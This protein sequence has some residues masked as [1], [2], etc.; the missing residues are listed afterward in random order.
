MDLSAA[1]QGR[2]RSLPGASAHGACSAVGQLRSGVAC[3]R[4]PPCYLPADGVSSDASIQ[5]RMTVHPA[6]VSSGAATT[7][8]PEYPPP[9]LVLRHRSRSAGWRPH[10]VSA[11]HGRTGSAGGAGGRRTGSGAGGPV[12]GGFGGAVHAEEAF[13]GV[14]WKPAVPWPKPACLPRV[15]ATRSARV[16]RKG[17]SFR[18][19][20]LAMPPPRRTSVRHSRARGWLRA[21]GRRRSQSTFTSAGR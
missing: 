9:S 3:S 2:S 13:G 8:S 17:S 7:T 1:T 16:S 19:I 4:L 14:P 15:T 21:Q 20:P 5:S 6:P 18:P 12:G 10:G 11:Q